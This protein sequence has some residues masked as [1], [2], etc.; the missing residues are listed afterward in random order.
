MAVMVV[1]TAFLNPSTSSSPWAS[2]KRMRFRDARL[3]A[4]SSRNMYSE[5]GL[6]P[7]MGA[8]PLQVCQRLTVSWNCIPGSPQ[9]QAASAMS[10]ISSRAGSCSTGA[11]SV[12][13]RVTQAPPVAAACMKA[14]V[15]RTEWLA[16]WKNTEP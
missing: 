10:S 13:A 6:E 1:S 4:E 11:P 14:S 2:R 9:I 7:R 16:F 3:H 15:A 12:T 5:Q 8:V